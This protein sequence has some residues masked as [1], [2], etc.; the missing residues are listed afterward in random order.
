MISHMISYLISYF[1]YQ[2]LAYCSLQVRYVNDAVDAAR[3]GSVFNG[4]EPIDLEFRP[5]R[6]EEDQAAHPGTGL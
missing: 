1:K 5:C 6:R 2:I 3:A 4:I